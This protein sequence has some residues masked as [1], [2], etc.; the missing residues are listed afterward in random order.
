[1]SG[2]KVSNVHIMF[3]LKMMTD[4]IGNKAKHKNINFYVYVGLQN[5]INCS[6]AAK[7]LT[8]ICLVCGIVCV[9]V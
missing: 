1:M 9:C 4:E 7:R 2:P 3:L 8:A 5:S 6:Q